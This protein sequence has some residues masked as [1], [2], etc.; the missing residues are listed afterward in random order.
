MRRSSKLILWGLRVSAARGL[1]QSWSRSPHKWR[2]LCGNREWASST[3]Q[4]HEEQFQTW[5]ASTCM[6]QPQM[7]HYLLSRHHFGRWPT[8][9]ALKLTPF[10]PR[11][12]TDSRTLGLRSV[13]SELDWAWFLNFGEDQVR[14]IQLEALLSLGHYLSFL[15]F[16]SFISETQKGGSRNNKE[17]SY[18]KVGQ[19]LNYL[20]GMLTP[21]QPLLRDFESHRGGSHTLLGRRPRSGWVSREPKNHTPSNHTPASSHI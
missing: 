9:S 16:S 7:R 5:G 19:P 2:A 17:I 13:L 18:L 21:E 20:E 4:S 6:C 15:D 12:R 1:A 14:Q 10:P 11:L 3:P 8:H